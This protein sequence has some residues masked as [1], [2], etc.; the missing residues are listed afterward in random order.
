MNKLVPDYE[1]I[2]KGLNGDWDTETCSNALKLL[3]SNLVKMRNATAL[4]EHMVTLEATVVKKADDALKEVQSE[5]RERCSRNQT[6]EEMEEFEKVTEKFNL[7]G[8]AAELATR[9]MECEQHI[10]GVLYESGRIYE[11]ATGRKI[12]AVIWA[13]VAAQEK[14]RADPEKALDFRVWRASGVSNALQRAMGRTVACLHDEREAVNVCVII[15]KD[16]R[17]LKM[18]DNTKVPRPERQFIIDTANAFLRLLPPAC[19]MLS[20]EGQ[21]FKEDHVA[22]EMQVH[23]WAAKLE[24]LKEMTEHD[25]NKYGKNTPTADK[26]FRSWNVDLQRPPALPLTANSVK[27]KFFDT[28]TDE[29]KGYQDTVDKHKVEYPKAMFERAAEYAKEL[30]TNVTKLEKWKAQVNF[31]PIDQVLKKGSEFF[32]VAA[33]KTAMTAVKTT[34]V[35]LE[36]LIANDGAFEKGHEYWKFNEDKMA[37][38]KAERTKTW[39]PVQVRSQVVCWEERMLETV[40]M[41]NLSQKA[42]STNIQ[43]VDGMYKVVTKAMVLFFHSIRSM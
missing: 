13:A 10:Q 19:Q 12:F 16:I 18:R 33:N 9:R 36:D 34:R 21:K 25:N 11:K 8:K 7:F 17:N 22:Q 4:K 40:Q 41:G 15:A 38:F 26:A 35:A 31:K 32:A 20:A 43:T 24:Y 29:T 3:S 27:Q 23:S 30:S 42:M 5:L 28:Y 14:L 37:E 39:V 2:E 6:Y 1:K